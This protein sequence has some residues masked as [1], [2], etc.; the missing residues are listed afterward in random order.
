VAIRIF[1]LSEGG[2]SVRGA[3]QTVAAGSKGTLRVEGLGAPLPWTAR[4]VTID[5]LHL[6]FA[7]DDI[8]RTTL[9]ALLDR[10]SGQRA[11]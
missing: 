8:G 1:D 10:S 2:A 4:A 5:G 9:R 11:A 7:L 3:D 6:A